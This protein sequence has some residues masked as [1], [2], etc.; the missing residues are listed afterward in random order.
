MPDQDPTVEPYV[1]PAQTKRPWTVKLLAALCVLPGTFAFI[2]G[3]LNLIAP[4]EGAAALGFLAG[5]FSF[6]LIGGG[7]IVLLFGVALWSGSKSV[8][9]TL[10]VLAGWNGFTSIISLDIVGVAFSGAFL[11]LAFVPVT[12]AFI[13]AKR[14]R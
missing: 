11:A 5:L 9:V 2:S 4:S 6:V 1:Q 10:I 12:R 8:W 13:D 14:R 3:L 7:L